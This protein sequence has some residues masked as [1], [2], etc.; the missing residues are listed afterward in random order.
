MKWFDRTVDGLTEGE[1]REVEE[2]FGFAFPP[3]MR[4]LLAKA[5]PVGEGWPEWRKPHSLA[6]IEW[7]DAPADAIES[8]VEAGFWADAWGERPDDDDDAVEEARRLV[9]L[10][11]ILVPVFENVYLPSRPVAAGNPLFELREDAIV[12]VAADLDDFLRGDGAAR[13]ASLR[14][15]EIEFWSELARPE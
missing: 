7:F 14:A 8:S 6:L 1:L 11:P 10:A 12:V 9:S 15:R 4:D 3:D 13:G 5:L 2:S